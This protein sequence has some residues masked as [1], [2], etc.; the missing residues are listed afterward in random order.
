MFRNSPNG[1]HLLA[2]LVADVLGGHALRR[3]LQPYPAVVIQRG[4]GRGAQ[5]PRLELRLGNAGGIPSGVEAVAE[6]V[7]GQR[8][9]GFVELAVQDSNKPSMCCACLQDE[10]VVD[11]LDTAL[12]QSTTEILS[13]YA[14]DLPWRAA[15][16][17]RK[18]RTR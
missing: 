14:D 10:Q 6:H 15:A 8:L 2:H 9:A 17:L 12:R 3:V 13:A 18:T 5:A 16:R 4:G 1:L 11:R 7:L